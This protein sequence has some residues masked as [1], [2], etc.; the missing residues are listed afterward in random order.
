MRIASASTTRAVLM[1]Q[2][3]DPPEGQDPEEQGLYLVLGYF[4]ETNAEALRIRERLKSAVELAASK[5]DDGAA[6]ILLETYTVIRKEIREA[7]LRA[8]VIGEIRRTDL[9]TKAWF[10]REFVQVGNGWD[11][12]DQLWPERMS[13]PEALA[14]FVMRGTRSIAGSS[15]RSWCSGS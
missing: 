15:D 6:R 10:A 14:A 13:H 8:E 9:G 1:R 5:D 3:N 11:D 12:L 4:R 7:T 2:G